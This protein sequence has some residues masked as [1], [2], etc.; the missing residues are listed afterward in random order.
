MRHRT[1]G[2][3]SRATAWAVVGLAVC[4]LPT[5]GQVT[6]EEKLG[7]LNEVAALKQAV[8]LLIPAG[9]IMAYAG[10]SAPPGWLLLDGSTVPEGPEY[11]KLRS[12]LESQMPGFNGSLPDFRGYFLR[13]AGDGRDVLTSQAQS[14]A[15]PQ[16]PLTGTAHPMLLG[17]NFRQQS[18]GGQG[19]GS[20]H[21]VLKVGGGDGDGPRPHDHAVEITGGGDGETRPRNIA[22]NFIIKY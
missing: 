17:R 20:G 6:A 21:F 5:G 13:A 3:R 1:Y 22:V 8:E 19:F 15:R 10:S 14:T 4:G 9:S 12:L 11:Q 2:L 16:N 7:L 18:P